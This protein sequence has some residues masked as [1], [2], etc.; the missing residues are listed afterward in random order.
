MIPIV[1]ICI[2]LTLLG[3]VSIIRDFYEI[4]YCQEAPAKVTGFKEVYDTES[5]HSVNAYVPIFTFQVNGVEYSGKSRREILWGKPDH[6]KEVAVLYNPKNPAYFSLKPGSRARG[7]IFLV[8]GITG[9]LS[10]WA[11]IEN[12]EDYF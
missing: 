10:A 7:I 8:V 6:D 1:L 3:L 11:S 2:V 12:I 9:L 5:P 4:M